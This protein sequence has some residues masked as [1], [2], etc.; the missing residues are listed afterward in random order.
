MQV[1]VEMMLKNGQTCDGHTMTSVKDMGRLAGIIIARDNDAQQQSSNDA[2]TT[3]STLRILNV[4]GDRLSGPQIAKVFGNAQ[5][6]TVKYYN[7]R[8]LTKMAKESIPDLYEQIH[9]LQ[10]NKEK[11]NIR[12]L[13]EEFPGLI[14]SFPEF[15][16]ETKY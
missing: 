2:N 3:T 6:E 1:A 13:K 10:T 7:N 11:T 16:D 15:V 9:F 4:A 12:S 14:T 5:K 8:E